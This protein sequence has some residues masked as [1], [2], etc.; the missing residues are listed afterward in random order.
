MPTGCFSTT[1][2]PGLLAARHVP[3]QLNV[4]ALRKGKKEDGESE[5]DSVMSGKT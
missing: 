2:P 3:E 1:H 4:V 5:N